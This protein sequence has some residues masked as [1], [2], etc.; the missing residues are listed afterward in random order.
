MLKT[1]PLWLPVGSLHEKGAQASVSSVLFRQGYLEPY[2]TL[3]QRDAWIPQASIHLSP[4]I[5]RCQNASGRPAK[6]T[7]TFFPASNTPPATEG[8]APR[9]PG[10]GASR[11][12]RGGDH[13]SSC[14]VRW[15]GAAFKWQLLLLWA[16]LRQN[17][18][19]ELSHRQE[20]PRQ[21][22]FHDRLSKLA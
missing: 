9:A 7:N 2:F 15:R 19:P 17:G 1:R 8:C 4:H 13:F 10:K 14:R 6:K 22:V 5:E 18:N 3:Q 21:I 20:L 11:K 12:P 16:D